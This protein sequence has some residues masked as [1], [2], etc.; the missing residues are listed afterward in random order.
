MMKKSIEN[1]EIT[2]ASTLKNEVTGKAS[3]LKIQRGVVTRQ[4]KFI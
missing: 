2:V 1:K 3:M 4:E